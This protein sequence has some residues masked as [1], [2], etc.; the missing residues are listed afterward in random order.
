MAG[1][2]PP[3]A[4]LAKVFPSQNCLIAGGEER[5]MAVKTPPP[6]TQCADRPFLSPSLA[7]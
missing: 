2:V 5:V 6:L 1:H 3:L 7:V 4:P